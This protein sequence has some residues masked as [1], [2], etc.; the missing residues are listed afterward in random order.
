MPTCRRVPG[1]YA[2]HSLVKMR[3]RHRWKMPVRCDGAIRAGGEL[4]S[5]VSGSALSRSRSLWRIVGIGAEMPVAEHRQLAH[6]A[7][8]VFETEAVCFRF[9]DSDARQ[10]TV[11]LSFKPFYFPA[12]TR[13]D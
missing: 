9:D 8:T 6:R 2:V 1:G 7:G 12:M 11:D 10:P 4:D 13:S 5:A 3:S